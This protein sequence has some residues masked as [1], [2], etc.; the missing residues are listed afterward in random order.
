MRTTS[1]LVLL[2]LAACNTD[3]QKQ[4]DPMP[5]PMPQPMVAVPA[6]PSM[7]SATPGTGF[8][9]LTWK[10]ESDTE[11]GFIVSRVTLS[12]VGDAVVATQL[13]E[14]VRVTADQMVLRDDVMPGQAFGYGVAAFNSA[15][16]SAVVALPTAVAPLGATSM[17]CQVAVPSLEDPDGDG[18]STAVEAAGWT[19]RINLNGAM[20][21]SETM[22][23]S[24]STQGDSDGDGLCDGE[25]RLLRT[26]PT[27]NDT[28]GD[29]LTDA[30]ELDVWGSSPINV[31]SDADSTGNSAF[32][33][34]SELMRFGTS[35]T[36]ADTDGDGRSDFQEVN[37]NST[38]PLVADLPQPRLELVGGIDITL[39]FQRTTGMMTTSS[40]TTSLARGMEQSTNRTS[41]VASS[42][43]SEVSVEAS[44]SVSGGF[45]DGIG[46]SVS[47]SYGQTETRMSETSTSF[48]QGST[49]TARQA[50][51]SATSREVTNSETITDGRLAVT[52]NIVNAGTRT[53]EL[54]DLVVTAMTRDRANPSRLTSIATLEMPQAAASVTLGDGQSAGPFRVEATIPTGVALD[55]LSNPTGL[56]FKP[57]SFQLVDRTGTNFSFSVG[58]TTANRT[59]LLV[60]DFGGDRPL[61]QYRVATN[62]ARAGAARLSGLKLSEALRAAGLMKGTGWDSAANPRGVKK[63]TRVRDVAAQAR[64]PMG[65]AKFWA[66]IAA[67]NT[68][69]RV[70]AA[71]RLLDPQADF[72]D[73]VLMPRDQVYLTFVA[74]EDG[75]GLFSREERLYRTSDLLADTDGD[76][77]SDRDEI[78]GGWDVFSTLPAFLGRSK[79]YSN[80]AVADADSDRLND[81]QEKLRGTDPNRSDT[82][83]DGITDDVDAEP[84]RGVSRPLAFSFGTLGLMNPM[85]V[86][87]D[88]QGNTVVLGQGGVDV[89]EDGVL[90]NSF[91]RSVF[92]A[93]FD[94]SG[95]RRWVHELE[96]LDPNTMM[97]N[98]AAGPNGRFY[99]FE[100]LYPGA[101]PGVTTGGFQLVELDALGQVV[102]TVP[103]ANVNFRPEFL[104]RTSA[105]DFVTMG[106]GAFVNGVGLPLRV[107]SFS[108]TGA[109]LGAREF[110]STVTTQLPSDSFLEASTRGITLLS[111]QCQ[112]LLFDRNLMPQTPPTRNLCADFTFVQQA[113]WLDSGDL[114]VAQ[115]SKTIRYDAMGVVRWSATVN[116]SDF[117]TSLLVDRAGRVFQVSQQTGSTATIRVKVIDATGALAITATPPGTPFFGRGALDSNGN[118]VVLGSSSNGLG[119]RLPRFGDIDLVVMRNPHL[120]FG[121]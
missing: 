114:Y 117:V 22:V 87:T 10:D 72:D 78:R 109:Q 50:Y 27:S 12:R 64:M 69:S 59:A 23:T 61:E 13:V 54:R 75:D 46:G 47:A 31:D 38:N 51:E 48:E 99:F 53:F 97:Q 57:A 111:N 70:P 107:L 101:L 95:R 113:K 3:P 102:S 14:L 29:G 34:G 60:V 41:G 11:D 37:Q 77:L 68:S 63:L 86:V 35:P 16:V 36:L 7:L 104:R 112:L 94:A 33:D 88:D 89:D 96:L 84:L 30:D 93:S 92:L 82:D 76:G 91:N 40:V 24:S 5:M 44:A 80:P 9:R 8:I 119:G 73:L 79:V 39:N 83:G 71:T 43:T 45:P 55:L 110:F 1:S 120:L 121:P 17:A 90:A 65:T 19:V 49:V 20:Q 2:A 103:V 98:L 67:D 66:V 74:D 15:G 52:F 118:Y 85:D 106:R 21:F 100:N 108:S 32:F 4:P 62:V 28:D 115:G 105:G 116:Q 58:E 26:N 81:A 18:L 6:A 56:V 42:S 25:E